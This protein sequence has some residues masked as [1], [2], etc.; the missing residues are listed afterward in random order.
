[1]LA[2]G[3][4]PL[5]GALFLGNILK[6]S[7]VTERLANT[8]RTSFIDSVTILLG[9]G[10]G[11]ST[12]A[13]KFLKWDVIKIFLVGSDSFRHCYRMWYTFCK[14]H[15]PILQ[16]KNQSSRRICRCLCLFLWPLAFLKP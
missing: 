3:A 12:Q 7:G 11:A 10:V 6:E 2:P 8:A 15:E 4:I 13:D 1:M 16:G 9:F 14:I 5:L